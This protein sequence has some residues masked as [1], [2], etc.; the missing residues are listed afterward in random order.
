MTF[1]SLAHLSDICFR[2]LINQ[3]QTVFNIMYA[4]LIFMYLLFRK[5]FSLLLCVRRKYTLKTS[6]TS[7][8]KMQKGHNYITV[9]DNNIKWKLQRKSNMWHH[10][11]GM[12]IAKNLLKV[13]M[14]VAGTRPK[15]GLHHPQ[16]IVL[17]FALILAVWFTVVVITKA[18]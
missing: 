18:L 10:G 6:D 15:L 7:T 5:K 1:Y 2:Y 12:G 9:R 4:M 14:P 17:P 8:V 13:A 16:V 11:E 3:M